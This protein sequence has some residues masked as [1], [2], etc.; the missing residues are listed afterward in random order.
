M[1]S[2]VVAVG[3][4]LGLVVA[5]PPALAYR[6]PLR[7][8]LS[9]VM[10]KQAE[11]AS[12]TMRVEADT[13]LFEVSGAPRGMPAVERTL[14]QAPAGMRKETEL[15]DGTRVEI[16]NDDKLLTKA[17]GQPDKNAKASVDFLFDFVT[18]TAPLDPDKAVERVLKD[19]KALGIN[20]EVVSFARFDGRVSYLIG[21]K[22][23]ENDKPQLWLDKDTLLPTRVVMVQK[24]ADGKVTRTDVRYLGWGSPIGGNWY[25]ASIEAYTD[26]KLVRR[27]TVRTVDRNVPVDATLF[28]LR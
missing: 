21:S 22:P 25:P 27:T 6:P 19:M 26:E 24:A 17:P 13:Q 15:A 10:E 2:V 12:K 3:V 5:S 23:W 8:L 28:Q 4:V 20:P 18:A 1:K 16:R 7:V 9:K 11:R 14:F